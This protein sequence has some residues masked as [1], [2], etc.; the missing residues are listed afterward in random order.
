[1]NRGRGVYVLP[2]KI[3]ALTHTLSDMSDL[4]YYVCDV[5]NKNK[6]FFCKNGKCVIFSALVQYREQMRQQP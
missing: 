5:G 4:I 6:D 3:F 1:M 2:N